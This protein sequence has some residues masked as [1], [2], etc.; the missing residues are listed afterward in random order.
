MDKVLRFNVT[1]FERILIN[2]IDN[3]RKY[4]PGRILVAIDSATALC[5]S[6][7]AIS[8]RR[9]RARRGARPTVSHGMGL[10]IVKE[11]TRA[12]GGGFSLSGADPGLRATATMKAIGWRKA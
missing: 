1:A 11:L 9:Q 6:L 2:L 3:A 4:A 12:N 5:R 7:C 8:A 10:A